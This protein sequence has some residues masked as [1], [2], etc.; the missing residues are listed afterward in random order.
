[1]DESQFKAFYDATRHALRAYLFR[2]LEIEAMVDD[3]SQETYLRFLNSRGSHLPVPEARKYLFTI[4]A[5]L[6]RDYWRRSGREYYDGGVGE[7]HIAQHDDHTQRDFTVQRVLEKL[8]IKQRSLL[9]LAYVEGY[10]HR[11]IAEIHK[12]SEKSV[13]VLL[14]RARNNMRNLLDTSEE[15]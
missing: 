4:A 6:V 13:R 12:V 7:V 2:V 15:L 9:W 1:M 14:S 5:N 11:E 3:I 8:P 10:S